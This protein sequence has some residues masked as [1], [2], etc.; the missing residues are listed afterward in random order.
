MAQGFKIIRVTDDTCLLGAGEETDNLV[1]VMRDERVIVHAQ[2]AQVLHIIEVH[3]VG[4]IVGEAAAVVLKSLVAE[5][6][7][8]HLIAIDGDEVDERSSYLTIALRKVFFGFGNLLQVVR[9]VIGVSNG[10]QFLLVR[11]LRWNSCLP[12]FISCV[13]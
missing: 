9:R 8:A 6:L 11:H 7:V 12:L 13:L 1:A 4:S 10:F 3:E 5:A 2:R